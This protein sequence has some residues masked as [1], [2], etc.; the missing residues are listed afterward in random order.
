M[1]DRAASMMQNTSGREID[2]RNLHTT[3]MSGMARDENCE[4][5]KETGGTIRRGTEIAIE[6]ET[7]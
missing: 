3:T 7:A 1:A 4:S 6:R 5:K 2:H